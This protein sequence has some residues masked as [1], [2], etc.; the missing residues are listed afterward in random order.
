MQFGP[1]HRLSVVAGVVAL[2]SPNQIDITASSAF[3][4]SIL[5]T[6]TRIGCGHI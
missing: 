6:R 1:A 5:S 4:N 2:S 3:V